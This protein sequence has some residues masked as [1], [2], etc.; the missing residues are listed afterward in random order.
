MCLNLGCI[1]VLA[2]ADQATNRRNLDARHSIK[3]LIEEKLPRISVCIQFNVGCGDIEFPSELKVLVG[4][5]LHFHTS[6]ESLLLPFWIETIGVNDFL[7]CAALRTVIVD[8]DSRL[9]EIH[10]FWDCSLLES[11]E[12]RARVEVI[13]R[14][15]FTQSVVSFSGERRARRC[16]VFVAVMN[17]ELLRLGRRRSHVFLHRRRNLTSE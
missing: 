7:L 5:A 14:E 16:P 3:R 12:I 15:A 13:G 1:D 17:E 6:S 11:I 8:R 9:R 4:D 2:E 10:G